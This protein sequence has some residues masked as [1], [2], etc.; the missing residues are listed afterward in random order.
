MRREEMNEFNIYIY[1]S[2]SEIKKLRLRDFQEISRGNEL[3]QC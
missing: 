1:L 3:T 2:K